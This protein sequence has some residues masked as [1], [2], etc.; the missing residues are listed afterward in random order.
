[1]R[2]KI[3]RWLLIS[4]LLAV[5][6]SVFGFTRPQEPSS[7]VA[8]AGEEETVSPESRELEKPKGTRLEQGVKL[9]ES[10]RYA[11]A[12]PFLRDAVTIAHFHLGRALMEQGKLDEAEAQFEQATAMAEGTPEERAEFF[13]HRGAV[14]ARQQKWEAAVQDL[15]KAIELN[16]RE[17]YNHYNIAMAFSRLNRPDRVVEHLQMFLKLA[18]ESPEAPRARALLR[19]IG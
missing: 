9:I 10:E 1:M 11:E 8:E 12:E 4:A 5:M 16:P 14:Y 15:E 13:R 3:P 6:S 2:H 19:T 17:P 7:E 18:P